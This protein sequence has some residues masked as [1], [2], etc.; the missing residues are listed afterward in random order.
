MAIKIVKQGDDLD[1]LYTAEVTSPQGNWMSPHPMPNDELGRKLLPMGCDPVEIR[2]ALQDAGVGQF[3]KETREAAKT[4]RPLLQAALAGEREVPAQGPST[5]ALLAYALSGFDRMV[6]LIW[7]VHSA[8][9][10]CDGV[11]NA[12]Q[13]SWSFLRLRKWGWLILDGERFG[14][15]P[16]GRRVLQYILGRD[17]NMHWNVK[18][19]KWLSKHPLPGD[20]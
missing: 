11:P 16:E 4:T 14:L 6:S 2:H 17:D 20:N 7:V 12:D 1:D 19:E 3:S 10:I 15:T 13:I 8:E 9:W 18:V 5:E